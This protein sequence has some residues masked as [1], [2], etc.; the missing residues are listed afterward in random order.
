MANLLM[1][2]AV[3][4]LLSD[5]TDRLISEGKQLIS[6]FKE[7]ISDYGASGANGKE[8]TELESR[9]EDIYKEI[10]GTLAET[11]AGRISDVTVSVIS[12]IYGS[13]LGINDGAPEREPAYKIY[14]GE[15]ERAVKAAAEGNVMRILRRKSVTELMPQKTENDFGVY[16]SS[17][18]D[19]AMPVFSYSEN[20]A[21]ESRPH[22]GVVTVIPREAAEA[23]AAK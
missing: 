9:C 10:R 6:D 13:A 4:E 18:A 17:I 19:R 21:C 7:V 12:E 1:R 8:L 23:I 20:R 11:V 22:R 2:Y 14:C 15:K 5:F 16:L 3:L